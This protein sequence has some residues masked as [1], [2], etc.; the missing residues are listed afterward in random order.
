MKITCTRPN[1]SEEINGI[2]FTRQKDGSV[3]ATGV[4]AEDAALFA[5]FEGYSVEDEKMPPIQNAPVD[6]QPIAP[7]QT[8]N[9]DPES[10]APA[11]APVVDAVPSDVAPVDTVPADAVAVV[12]EQAPAEAKTAKRK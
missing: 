1:A 4:S 2:P 3:M 8:A 10:V 6:E 12:A 5:D 11:D 7:L 9:P